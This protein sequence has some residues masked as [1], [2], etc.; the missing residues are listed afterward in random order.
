MLRA[1]PGVLQ[2]P[3]RFPYQSNRSGR[4]HDLTVLKRGGFAQRFIEHQH[5]EA[6]IL[7]LLAMDNLQNPDPGHLSHGA[8][9][10]WQPS[11]RQRYPQKKER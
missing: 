11:E 1:R 10:V 2:L 8:T 3:R 6:A 4:G 7:A 5:V 9:T